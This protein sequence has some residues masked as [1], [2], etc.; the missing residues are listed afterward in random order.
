MTLESELNI[1]FH[2]S[3]ICCLSLPLHWPENRIIDET[4][5]F[6]VASA[7]IKKPDDCLTISVTPPTSV[8]RIGIPTLIASI[9][10]T[11]NP[12]DE[13]TLTNRSTG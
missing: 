1:D 13:L 7:G 4:M 6:K 8:A 3:R 9:M 10:E 12:S 5:S 2:A 11:G